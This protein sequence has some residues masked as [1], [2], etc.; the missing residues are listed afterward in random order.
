[1]LRFVPLLLLIAWA[2]PAAA[3]G[4]GNIASISKVEGQNCVSNYLC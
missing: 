2:T 4:A 1:M 3:F